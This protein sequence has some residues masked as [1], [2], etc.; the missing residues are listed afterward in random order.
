MGKFIK[1]DNILINLDRL[2]SVKHE[3]EMQTRQIEQSEHYMA[4][5]DT[6]QLVMLSVTDGTALIE[7]MST[8]VR[9]DP[10]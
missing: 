9:A 8:P 7:R 10:I 3:P 4:L 2:I 1:L 5:F 6:G